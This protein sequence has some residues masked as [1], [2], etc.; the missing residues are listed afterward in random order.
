MRSLRTL[1]W[2]GL[3]AALPASAQAILT[4]TA[5]YTGNTTVVPVV[6]ADFS[7]VTSLS[8]GGKTITFAPSMLAL[9]TGTTWNFWGA[10]PNT[11]SSTPR[12]LASDGGATVTLT[13]SSPVNTF[14]FE[15]EPANVAGSPFSM[16]V[17]FFNGATQVAQVTR[18]I[19][20]NGA[21]LMAFSLPTPIT[22]AVVTAPPGA[23]GFAIAQIRFGN[24]FLFAP[25]PST[26]PALGPAGLGTLGLMLAA[27]GSLLA[28]RRIA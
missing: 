1:L 19:A 2:I 20:Y 17:T 18:T 27:A 7:S 3:A 6:G 13:L 16:T 28:R 12:V 8:A 10:P 14:G 25:P 9:T 21:L 26:V 22:S 4:P 15:L 5:Q 24:T 11:E 23:G